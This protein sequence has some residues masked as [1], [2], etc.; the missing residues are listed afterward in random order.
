MKHNRNIG[1][2]VFIISLKAAFLLSI[3]ARLR[4]LQLDFSRIFFE[5]SL[6]T[7]DD[8]IIFWTYFRVCSLS[9]RPVS[10]AVNSFEDNRKTKRLLNANRLSYANFALLYV[11]D[12]K[13]NDTISTRGMFK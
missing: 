12:R 5:R 3:L 1:F 4:S 11:I 7:I 8:W 6:M 13:H 9:F 10:H 2:K